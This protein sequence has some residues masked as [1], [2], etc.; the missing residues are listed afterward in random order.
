MKREQLD[1]WQGDFG[2]SYISRNESQELLASNL[3]FFSEIFSRAQF[4]P[5]SFIEFGANIGMNARALKLLYPNSKFA[6]I[7][8]NKDAHSQLKS[9]ADEA[10]LGAIEE[11]QIAAQYDV[12]FTKGVLIHINPSNLQIVYEKLYNSSSKFI[13]VAEYYNR[14]PVSVNYRGHEDRLFKRDFAGEI[15]EKYSDLRLSSYGFSYHRAAFPQD[16]I[17]WFLLEK[18]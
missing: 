18:K 12:S 2:T 7:E 17:S 6:G 10:L 14:E 8:I 11:V 9:V 15:L 1:F 13:L 5:T 16:D 4:S 3:N